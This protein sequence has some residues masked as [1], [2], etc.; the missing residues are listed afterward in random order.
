MN[1]NE[2]FEK[3]T[4]LGVLSMAESDGRV[5]TAVYARPHVMEDGSIALIMPNRLTHH[6]LQSNGHAAYLF[7]ENEPGYKGRR[8]HLSKIREDTDSDLLHSLRRKVYPPELEEKEGYR[9]VVFFKVDKVLPLI[10]PGEV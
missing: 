9:Y 10:G 3:R 5:N 1:L 6:N 2:Y 8:L 4:G 7:R